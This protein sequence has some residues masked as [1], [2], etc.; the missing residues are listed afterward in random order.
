ML[1]RVFKEEKL[2]QLIGHVIGAGG[3]PEPLPLYFAG[4]DLLTPLTRP[5]G[6]PIGNLTSQLFG[7]FYLNGFDHWVKQELGVRAYLRFMD[8][9]LLLDDDAGRLR[10]LASRCAARL[11]ELRLRVHPRKCVLRR[12]SE[13]IP[14]LG[15]VICR[16]R[17]RVR[18]ATV[19]RFRR[20][21]RSLRKRGVA[22]LRARLAAWRGHV[23]LARTHRRRAPRRP[24]FRARRKPSSP[25]AR[26]FAWPMLATSAPFPRHSP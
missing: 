12:T 5:R 9:V 22:D 16:D 2:L 18:G 24:A 19:R 10:V 20:R 6:L 23:Q 25:F 26:R 14:L 4:D 13:G 8:D 11:A 1:A 3:A 21:T 7:N 17:I 15:Y